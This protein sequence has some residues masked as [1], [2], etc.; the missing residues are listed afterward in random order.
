MFLYINILGFIVDYVC[1]IFML[2]PAL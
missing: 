2:V 1:W